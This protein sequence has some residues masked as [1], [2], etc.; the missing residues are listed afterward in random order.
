MGGDTFLDGIDMNLNP[1]AHFNEL[2]LKQLR[3]IIIRQIKYTADDTYEPQAKRIDICLLLSAI[4]TRIDIE[5]FD[6]GFD[7]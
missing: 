7:L 5:I 1:L 3:N 2:Q 6:R 4:S